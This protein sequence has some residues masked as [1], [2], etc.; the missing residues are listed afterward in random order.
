MILNRLLVENELGLA[1]EDSDGAAIGATRVGAVFVDTLAVDLGAVL[2]D[3][4]D[5]EVCGSVVIWVGDDGK[6][7]D[8]VDVAGTKVER[9][10]VTDARAG[11]SP[12]TAISLGNASVVDIVLGGGGF[13]LPVVIVILIHY[14]ERLCA[15]TLNNGRNDHVFGARIIGSA[16]GNNV[17]KLRDNIGSANAP[18]AEAGKVWVCAVEFT[19]LQKAADGF[20]IGG[21]VS[22]PLSLG[23]ARGA[24]VRAVGAFG[25]RATI[26]NTRPAAKAEIIKRDDTVLIGRELGAGVDT[27]LPFTRGGRRRRRRGGG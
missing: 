4:L 14:S 17:T 23:H 26:G 6:V 20:A 3:D 24:C 15:A 16:D 5:V 9:G 19:V 27:V 12:N 18:C 10:P 11:G 25:A 13:A 2:G 8:T 21:L 7:G 22:G 1:A